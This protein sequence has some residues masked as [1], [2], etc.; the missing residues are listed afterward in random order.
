MLQKK[1]VAEYSLH[2]CC[3]IEKFCFHASFSLQWITSQ[4]H[5]VKMEYNQLLLQEAAKGTRHVAIY[6]LGAYYPLKFADDV[7]L[8]VSSQQPSL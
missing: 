4:G 3:P 7:V 8:S 5:S 1:K 2:I 6:Y